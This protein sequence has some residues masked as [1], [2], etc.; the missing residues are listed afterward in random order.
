MFKRRTILKSARPKHTPSCELLSCVNPKRAEFSFQVPSGIS[1]I[2]CPVTAKYASTLSACHASQ[3][4]LTRPTLSLYGMEMRVRRIDCYLKNKNI[5]ASLFRS[6]IM[7][8]LNKLM[9]YLRLLSRSGTTT[10][11]VAREETW[12]ISLN[13]G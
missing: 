9:M 1:S 11:F 5:T 10:P 2:Q 13:L 12:I 7:F 8:F 4:R 6:S 3:V